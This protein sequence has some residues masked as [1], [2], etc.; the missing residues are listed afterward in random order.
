MAKKGNKTKSTA[1][2]PPEQLPS[3]DKKEKR[4]KGRVELTEDQKRALKANRSKVTNTTSW[5]GKLP[6][7]LLH[8]I[9]VKR[10]WNKVEYVMNRI[11]DKG[12]L[13]FAVLSYTDPKTKETLTVRMQDPTFDK[14]TN[15]GLLVPQETPAEARHYAATLALAR[16]AH[17]T[18]MHMMLPPNHKKI[19]HEL[20][21]YK[22]KLNQENPALCCKIFDVDPFKTLV[23]D[24]KLREKQEKERGQ[25]LESE[26]KAKKPPI[27][28]TSLKQPEEKESSA[29]ARSRKSK[30]INLQVHTVKFPRKVWEMATYIDLEQSTRNFIENSLKSYVDWHIKMY[31]G[32]VTPEREQLRQ[33]LLAFGFRNS[34]VAEA[35]KY[36]DALS[37]LLF[38][39]PED[40]L[41][42]FFHRRIEDTKMKVELATLPLATRNMIDRLMESGFSYEE[43]LLALEQSSFDEAEAAGILTASLAPSDMQSTEISSDESKEIWYQELDALSSIYEADQHTIIEKDTCFMMNL[44]EELHLKV[45]FY[46]TKYYP[47]QLPGIIVSTFDKNY[48]LPNYIKQQ[49]VRKLLHYIE[50]S[51]IFGDILLF[52]IFGWL[53]EHLV[54]IIDNPGPLFFETKNG[55]GNLRDQ[56]SKPAIK[57]ES[58]GRG[59]ATKTLTQDE[60]TRIEQ[61]YLDRIKTPQ[62][63]EMISQRSKLPAWGKQKRIVEMV[64]NNDVILVT[65]ETGSGK[66]TQ[67]VQF[68]LDSLMK[69]KKDFSKRKIICT[70][71]RR[72]SAIGLAERVSDERRTKCGSEVGYI[73]RGGNKTSAYTRIVFMTTGVLVRI[74]QGDKTFLSNSIVVIDEV[75]ERSVDTDLLVI[76][77]KNIHKK[78][79]G[80]KIVLMSATV[81]VEI[82]KNYFD[83]MKTC[84]I[85]GRTFPIKDYFLEDILEELDFKIKRKN[86]DDI[87]FVDEDS[88]F[89]RPTADSKFF[90]SGQINFD[91]LA[92]TVFHVHKR[93]ISENNNGSIIVFLPGVGEI[94]KCCQILSRED[95]NSDLVILPLHSSLTTEAQKRVFNRIPGK[96]KVVVSTNIAETSITIDDCVA[97]IDTGRAKVMDYNPKENI[98]KL[99]ETF[100]SKAEVKQ[101][102]GR[103]G[104]V[105]EGYS[106]KLFSKNVFN[107]MMESPIPEIKRI[108]LESLYLSVK[109]LSITN[110]M[111]FLATGI[112]PPPMSSFLKSEQMLIRTGLLR[113][114]DKSLTELGKYV[115][116]MPV[117]DTKHG[118]LLVYSIIFGCT[119]IGVLL[120]SVLG[121]GAMPFVG[122]S[123][124]RDKIKAI[125]SQFKGKGDIL[126]ITEIVS[127][128]LDMKDSSSRRKFMADNLLSYRKLEEIQ[129]SITQYYSI[130]ADA[131]LLP[132]GYKPGSVEH[133]NRNAGN[134]NVLKCIITGAFYPNV[135]RVQYPDPKFIS[136]SSGAVEVDSEAKL[137][138]FWI[139][140]EEY[141]DH[142]S[143]VEPKNDTGNAPLPTTRAFIHPSSVLFTSENSQAQPISAMDDNIS[144][145]LSKLTL[146]SSKAPFVVYNA[147]FSTS[148]LFLRDLTP[149]STL[150]LL[151][152]GGPIH[153]E[154]H[155]TEHSPGIVVDQWLPIRTWCKNGVLLKEVRELLDQVLQKR[156]EDTTSFSPD[157]KEGQILKLIEHV[158]NIE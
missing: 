57:K 91:L 130:L 60:V 114:E 26:K 107:G 108:P 65:G 89:L 49:I 157:D 122:P 42:P 3:N 83:G 87:D 150:A 22:K 45:K 30:Q 139:I 86:F 63:G 70:Q 62:Y 147:A 27:M 13:A 135:A 149:T 90:Q 76:L 48:K 120:T 140:N 118:K 111:K 121:A 73:I 93:L 50:S 126:A 29:N 148:K 132:L 119:D 99:V 54:N 52:N 15:S 6:H 133:L 136:V 21:D 113:E 12:M 127:Q 146:S 156:L 104:R 7:T 141:I 123:E 37:F 144:P 88:A 10:K 11:G 158:I 8:E 20:D 151:L 18:N 134:Y 97:T 145:S 33:Q 75:H 39:L 125:L 95:N 36:K 129:N 40:D 2:P 110:V 61:E 14:K 85:E 58:K 137:T 138:K 98:T 9:T 152:F 43:C 35:M 109:S 47:S 155:G 79:P 4:G 19:W 131:G 41:P 46:K 31:N 117:M 23:E 143:S 67:V 17:N 106:Y 66:S 101:R 77:L 38:H 154:I 32:E 64:E 74:L 115:S 51:G 44:S 69:D 105:Q 34:H 56:K 116:M 5:T 16:I 128:Y 55:E 59:R 82:F 24:R 68:L 102:R 1:T 53:Q 100:I 96:R 25:T 81:N 92:D 72:I 124:N 71:P 94:N 28:V 84:H 153:Y 142:L 103:A 78:I 80:M 112:D